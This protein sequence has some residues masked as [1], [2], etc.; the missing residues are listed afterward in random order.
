MAVARRSRSGQKRLMGR[1][2]AAGPQYRLTGRGELGRRGESSATGQPHTLHTVKWIRWIYRVPAPM[3]KRPGEVT[4]QELAARLQVSPGV[5]YYWAERGI[6]DSRR[7][8]HG[9]PLWIV[10]DEIKLQELRDR[11]SRSKKMRKLPDVQ[12]L[13]A[14]GAV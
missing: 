4:V 14:R 8:N 10:L 6:I 5:V 11:V 7:I 13:A 12:N 2:I 1:M 3:L 9:S